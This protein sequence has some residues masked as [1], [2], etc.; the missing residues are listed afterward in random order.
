MTY[1]SAELRRRIIELSGDC[2]E[3]NISLQ[4]RMVGK[5][6]KIIWLTV[7]HTTITVK[8]QISPLPTLKQVNQLFYIIHVVT[9]GAIT[10]G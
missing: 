3:L 6:M 7:A 2:C 9:I 8:G 4:N 5:R 1:V 10:L